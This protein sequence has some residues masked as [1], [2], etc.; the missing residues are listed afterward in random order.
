MAGITH[1]YK[2]LKE[3]L[4]KYVEELEANKEGERVSLD[5]MGAWYKAAM[6]LTG[7]TMDKVS[8]YMGRETEEKDEPLNPLR[9]ALEEIAN[10]RE[11]IVK[12]ENEPGED[13]PRF[14]G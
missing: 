4:D 14:L 5:P 3:Q 6:E 8:T 9:K 2:T 10:L 1:G 11:A 12:L 7:E 13:R